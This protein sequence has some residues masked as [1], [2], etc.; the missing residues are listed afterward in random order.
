MPSRFLSSGQSV[1]RV[2]REQCHEPR[3][4]I[5]PAANPSDYVNPAFALARRS[6][7]E[8]I[9]VISYSHACHP[10]TLSPSHSNSEASPDH[11][12][13]KQ[14]QHDDQYK[15]QPAARA[16]SPLTAVWP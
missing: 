15:T 5:R 9:G 11:V 10:I 14:D 7:K 3:F 6:L 4:A 2:D 13:Q 1:R 12:G 16:V 8:E